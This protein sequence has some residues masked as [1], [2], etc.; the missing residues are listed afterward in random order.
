MPVTVTVFQ[1]RGLK[2][3]PAINN[4][5]FF[6]VPSEPPGRFK[7]AGG[8]VSTMLPATGGGP[9][10]GVPAN[11]YTVQFNEAQAQIEVRDPSRLLST[12]IWVQQAQSYEVWI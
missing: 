11:Q 10:S 4:A 8:G 2:R 6:T 12:R 1:R 3:G 9:L 7:G 5:R